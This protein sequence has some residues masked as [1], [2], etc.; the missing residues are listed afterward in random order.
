MTEMFGQAEKYKIKGRGTRPC[1][2]THVPASGLPLTHYCP[3]PPMAGLTA[4][5]TLSSQCVLIQ[6]SLQGISLGSFVQGR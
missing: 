2:L 1:P 4:G 3:L 6:G 5:E